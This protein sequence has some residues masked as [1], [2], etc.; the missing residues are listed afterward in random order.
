MLDELTELSKTYAQEAAEHEE[1]GKEPQ[2]SI[3]EDDAVP[4]VSVDSGYV[5]L[6]S[7]GES[8]GGKVWECRFRGMFDEHA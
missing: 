2:P 6:I 3:A 1:Q 4:V 8:C 7:V 5:A